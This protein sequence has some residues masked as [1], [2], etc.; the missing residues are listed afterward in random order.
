[1][2]NVK[3]QYNYISSNVWYVFIITFAFLLAGRKPYCIKQDLYGKIQK[4]RKTLYYIITWYRNKYPV[5]DYHC[6]QCQSKIILA[7]SRVRI[8]IRYY[9]SHVFLNSAS[10][11]CRKRRNRATMSRLFQP[12]CFNQVQ[13]QVWGRL[14]GSRAESSGS[15]A[16]TGS[17]IS[18]L[19][20]LMSPSVRCVWL[21]LKR[22]SNLG[23]SAPADQLVFIF[24]PSLVREQSTAAFT[25]TPAAPLVARAAHFGCTKKALLA[26]WAP[27]GGAESRYRAVAMRRA[28]WCGETKTEALLGEPQPVNP[29]QDAETSNKTNHFG[30]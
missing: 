8:Y 9:G 26:P 5:S 3:L 12:S 6:D 13:S 21:Y 14:W 24:N 17:I 25:H 19:N 15:P 1:M 10:F 27:P 4:W 22:A 23:P 20:P 28:S 2:S 7:F 11:H 29:Q 30:K 16:N 18:Q